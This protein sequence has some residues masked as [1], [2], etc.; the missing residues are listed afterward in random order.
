M[1]LSV[2]SLLACDTVKPEL[3]DAELDSR[4]LRIT[5]LEARLTELEATVQGQASTIE[6]QEQ[7]LAGEQAA[8][9]AALGALG[10]TLT[11]SN[12]A[13]SARITVLEA[14]D[15]AHTD[16]LAA[17]EVALAVLTGRADAT[18]AELLA[19]GEDVSLLALGLS[20]AET[21]LDLLE[22]ADTS[23]LD[24]RVSALEDAAGAAGETWSANG[25]AVTRPTC[26]TGSATWHEVVS[27]DFRAA[28]EGAVMVAM[29][30]VAWTAARLRVLDASGATVGSGE[31]PAPS[32]DYRLALVTTSPV[33]AGD[34]YTATF[35]VSDECS[36]GMIYTTGSA[37]NLTVT[38]L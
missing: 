26:A 29:N 24:A 22:S 10:E 35:E 15:L 25:Y 28:S 27:V 14:Q 34:A 8:R 12:D 2:L 20:A 38:T 19:L 4:D 30:G 6:A 11:A 36:I 37:T 33:R 32:D 5:V 16:A 23:G 1:F 13:L 18:D 7:A 21:R 31:Q 3:L 17:H 9:D